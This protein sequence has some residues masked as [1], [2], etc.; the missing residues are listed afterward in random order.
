MAATQDGS[1]SL[2]S[3]AARRACR[4]LARSDGKAISG[5]KIVGTF[6]RVSRANSEEEGACQ[7]ELE[8]KQP[9]LLWVGL[10]TPKQ[11]RFMAAYLPRLH[12]TVAFGVGAAFDFHTGRMREAPRWMMRAGLQWLHRLC[13]DPRRLWKRYAV[14]IPSFLGRLVL[15]TTGLKKYP[16]TAANAAGGGAAGRRISD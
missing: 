10:S 16:L 11:E 4:T 12:A 2:T 13:S 1:F 8:A 3:R 7:T 6:A 14:I 9:D 15:Q 5:V